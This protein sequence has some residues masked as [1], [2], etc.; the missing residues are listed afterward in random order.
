MMRGF[1]GSPGLHHWCRG[2]RWSKTGKISLP[3]VKLMNPKQCKSSVYSLISRMVVNG[4]VFKEFCRIIVGEVPPDCRRQSG[5]AEQ[6]L[7]PM[8]VVIKLP[9][10]CRRQSLL[11][12]PAPHRATRRGVARGCGALTRWDSLASEIRNTKWEKRQVREG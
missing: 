3:A 7:S 2:G 9:P 4:S 10:D 5:T 8:T 6:P 12:K 11:P 1:T